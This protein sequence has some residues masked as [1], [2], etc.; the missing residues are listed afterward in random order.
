[1]PKVYSDKELEAMSN[2]ELY[3]AEIE[4]AREL[5]KAMTTF[6]V[7]QCRRMVDRIRREVER[8]E[9]AREPR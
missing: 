1:M 5:S 3:V 6:R 8:R 9:D 4:W 7:S 2:G